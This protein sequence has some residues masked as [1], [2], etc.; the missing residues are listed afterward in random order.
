[1]VPD[2][3]SVAFG[4]RLESLR[5]ERG[6]RR[7][8]FARRLGIPYT[9]LRSY[10]IGEREPGHTF[11]VAASELLGVKVDYLLGRTEATPPP[12]NPIDDTLIKLLTQ[13]TPEETVKI[14]AYI[15]GLIDAR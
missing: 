10:E 7:S 3:S 2:E 12:P 15:Q 4:K 14:Q 6:F 5:T 13:L 8:D 11:L 9:T 1:M